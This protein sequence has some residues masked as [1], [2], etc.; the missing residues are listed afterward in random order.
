VGA[1]FGVGFLIGPALGGAS[2]LYDLSAAYPALQAY[3]V[4][5]FSFPAL[6]ALLIT[7]LNLALVWRYFDET[8]TPA[9]TAAL[10]APSI[11]KVLKAL[12]SQRDGIALTYWAWFLFQVALAGTTF[13]LPFHAAQQL[14]YGPAQIT[15]LLIVLGVVLALM[16]GTY[17]RWASPRLGPRAMLVHGL[18]FTIPAF[19]LIGY[20]QTPAPMYAGLVLLGIGGAQVQPCLSALASLYAPGAA[21][22]RAQGDFRALGALGRVIG[23]IA[24]AG[25]Y[26]RLGPAES[27]YASAAFLALPIAVALRLPTPPEEE[28]APPPPAS[29]P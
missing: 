7:L 21:Q 5:P 2:S 20:A 25:I 22:G 10:A 6:I 17:V 15:G 23:R 12:R 11:R 24:V 9:R 13:A 26:W 3:G 19:A 29:V 28:N 27:Y 18:A 1:A 4:N 8:L 14:G 16:Q